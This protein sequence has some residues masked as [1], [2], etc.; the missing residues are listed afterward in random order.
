MLIKKIE[1]ENFRQYKGKQVINFAT[2]PEHNVTI[3][4]GKNTAGKTTLLQAFKWCFYG[5]TQ[6]DKKDPHN[7]KDLLLNKDIELSMNNNQS[8]KVSVKIDLV[9]SDMSYTIF[10]KAEYLKDDKGVHQSSVELQVSYLNENYES[11][12]IDEHKAQNKVNEI[13]PEALSDYFFFDTERIG[14]I[15]NKA[16]IKSSVEGLLGLN[17][18]ASGIK[19]LSSG[20][21]RSV[22]GKLRSRL[23]LND[24]EKSNELNE[25]ISNLKERR[26]N[27]GE[28]IEHLEKEIDAYDNLKQEATLS[29]GALSSVKEDQEEKVKLEEELKSL[30]DNFIDEIEKPYNSAHTSA[31]LDIFISTLIP[32]AEKILSEAN[33]DDKGVIG[34]TNRTIEELIN[35]G[36]CL[37]GTHIEEGNE[38]YQ[39]LMH[40]KS[41]VPPQ[42]LGTSI[43]NFKKDFSHYQ[44]GAKQGFNHLD[45]QYKL[46]SQ[47]KSQMDALSD[48]ISALSDKIYGKE[49]ARIHEENIRIYTKKIKDLESQRSEINANIIDIEKQLKQLEDKVDSIAQTNKLNIK[50]YQYIA[51]AEAILNKLRETYS[52]KEE[53]VRL[54][55]ENKVNEIFS[56]MYHGK[57]N[58]YIDDK[59]CVT[60]KNV[61]GSITKPSTGLETVKNF[62]FIT[63]LVALAKAKI[64]GNGGINISSEPYPLVMDAP[65]SN[66]DE[67]HVKNIARLVPEV[68]EQVL[69][70]VMEKDWQHAQK[71]MGHKVGK[72]YFLNKHTETLTTIDN[73]EGEV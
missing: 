57:R 29:L 24:E 59:Y 20:D 19:H 58:I 48:R 9:H 39:A 64:L 55:L 28:K 33:V 8:Q 3:L 51:Y 15:S 21:K 40:E 67:E 30:E 4:L 73:S 31:A 50:T 63:G 46:L 34:V 41:F 60:L 11:L 65:F 27:E 14:T 52:N 71:V 70:F 10:R 43:S 25:Q 22:L 7:K 56:D 6:F 69:I 17:V 12:N 23:N 26:K 45:A 32:D 13:L 53:E 5:V 68:A 44:K 38:A 37:C 1:L 62:A 54:L 47:R 66:A 61:D 18:I 2:N 16:D 42:S 36:R 49:D 35:R 72:T